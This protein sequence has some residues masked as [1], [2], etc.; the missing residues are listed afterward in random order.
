LGSTGTR[1]SSGR[2]RKNWHEVGVLVAG[3]GFDWHAEIVFEHVRGSLDLGLRVPGGR[4]GR[5]QIL[6]RLIDL[7]RGRGLQIEQRLHPIEIS[8]RQR[9]GGL[10]PLQLGYRVPILR[11]FLADFIRVISRQDLLF[12]NCVAEIDEDQPYE[13]VSSDAHAPGAIVSPRDAARYTQKRWHRHRLDRLR[14]DLAG[15]LL[16]GRQHDLIFGRFCL[17]RFRSGCGRAATSRGE[18]ETPADYQA[19]YTPDHRLAPCAASRFTT[20]C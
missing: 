15:R 20:L 16:V 8:F 9:R 7:Q 4:F 5:D 18:Q 11:T 6:P 13:T 17:G 10:E 3:F 2:W 1:R 19:A 14:L 12:A